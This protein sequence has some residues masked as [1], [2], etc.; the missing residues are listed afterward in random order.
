MVFRARSH[1]PVV[2]VL[3]LL[4]GGN[5]AEGNAELQR[6]GCLLDL[7]LESPNR[8]HELRRA[9]GREVAFFQLG[10]QALK[11]LAKR[12][13]TVGG[14][15][16][17]LFPHGFEFDGVKVLNLELM[18]ATPV[19]ERGSGDVELNHQAGVSP[20]PGTEFDESLNNLWCMHIQSG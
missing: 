14:G 15:R 6:P 8:G 12:F 20:A 10:L 7:A 4:P 13:D 5:G 17:P 1:L 3:M 19:N 16:E 11:L 18:L 9:Q 2:D